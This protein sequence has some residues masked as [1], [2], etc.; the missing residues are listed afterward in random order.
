MDCDISVLSVLEEVNKEKLYLDCL[1]FHQPLWSN[2]MSQGALEEA[3]NNFYFQYKGSYFQNEITSKE[4]IDSLRDMEIRDTDVFIVT[5][6]KSGTIWTQQIVSLILSEEYRNGRQNLDALT[7]AP[8]MECNILNID[9]ESHPS[10]RLF[11]SHFPYFL[12]PKGLEA[13]KGKIIYVYRNPKDVLVSFYHFIKAIVKLRYSV[14]WETFF[15]L[16]MSGRLVGGSWFDHIKGWYTQKEHY[17]I[18]FMSYEEMKKDL[19]SAVLKI[20]KFLD[21]KLDAQAIDVVVEKATFNN[22][23]CDPL[24][25]YEFIPKDLANF[26]ETKFLRKG[27]HG[28]A[29]DSAEEDTQ[30]PALPPPSSIT[31]SD[32]EGIV[33]DWKNNMTLAQIEEFDIVYRRK[34]GDLPIRM[35]WDICSEERS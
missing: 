12:M 14:D 35:I 20:S 34:I 31:Q 32:I 1:S 15:D 27:A 25:N 26:D 30:N 6:P 18:L 16:F 33:G 4:V 19:R 17:N 7:R 13:N 10:P 9:F 5:Y 24:A 28:E 2:K 29:Q 3:L 11:T 23:K 22:M 21:V 8:W